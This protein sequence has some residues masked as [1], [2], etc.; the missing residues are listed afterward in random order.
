M[1][2]SAGVR[3]AVFVGI[4]AILL[5]GASVAGVVTTDAPPERSDATVDKDYFTSEELLSE[6]EL[7]PRSGEIE[8]AD[9]PSRTVLVSTDGDPNDLEPVVNALVA[10]GHEVRIH[11]GQTT[12]APIPVA[13]IGGTATARTGGS[14]AGDG[15][16]EAKLD[17]S[18]ALLI[19]GGSQIDERDHDAIEEFADAGGP[20]AI[21]TEPTSG[22]GGSAVDQ[23]TARFGMS[24]G[25]GYLY[26]M[27]END[28]NF[29][30]VYASGASGEL[31]EGVDTVVLDRAAPVESD[32]GEPIA[33]AGGET[34]YSTTREAGEFNVAV[35]RENAVVIGDS[36]I[37]RP[38]NYNR[39]DN[40]RLLGNVL[41]FL[42]GGP[43]DPYS[44]TDEQPTEEPAGQPTPD[45][46]ATETTPGEET[47]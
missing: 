3:I 4:V 38:L 35:Q 34:H 1:S 39:G 19:V 23:L 30:R 18:D 13:G 12:A 37:V 25:G 21:A 20:V 40:Q 7:T 42:T 31:A 9:Q 16:L 44:P 26:N 17:E 32:G 41:A 22:F 2:D 8:F 33:T 27:H 14:T 28:A 47:G 29:Q 36:D 46:G 10:H 5:V 24:V 6:S 45:G 11:G 43:E 15:G